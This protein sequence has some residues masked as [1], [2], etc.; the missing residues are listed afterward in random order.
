MLEHEVL[1]AMATGETLAAAMDR[2][3]RRV[4]GLAPAAICS[5]LEVD[6]DG[7]LHPLAAPSLPETYSAALDGI[8]IGPKV[9]SC[10][11]A[12][13]LRREVDVTDIATDPLWDDYR[14]LVEPLGLRGC[15]SS[16]ILAADGK[17]LGTFAFYYREKDGARNIERHIVDACVPLCAIVMEH[18][19]ARAERERL[20]YHDGLTGLANRAAFFRRAQHMIAEAGGDGSLTMLYLDL[21]GFKDV[22][23]SLGHFAG[24]Q[25]LAAVGQRLLAFA[26]N[27][28]EVARIGGDEFA[29]LV[30]GSDRGRAERLAHKL[31][32]LFDRPIEVD[33]QTVTMRAS[34]GIAFREAGDRDLIELLKRADLA[35]YRAKADGGGRPAFFHSELAGVVL[36]RRELENDLNK[37]IR[38]REFFL[39]Y[40]PIVDLATGAV[41]GCEG[42]VRW[43]HP[44]AGL[45]PPSDFIGTAEELGLIIPIGAWVL[46]EGCRAAT[47]WPEGIY[48]AINLSAVQLREPGFD[49]TVATILSRTGLP[50]SR[51]QLEITESVLLA[52]SPVTRAT[53]SQLRAIGVG[54]ALDDFGTGYSSL[55]SIRAFRPDTIKIDQ[56][57]IGELGV[58]E[59]ATTIVRAVIALAGNLGMTTTAEG[60]E[61]AEQARL[62]VEEGC[63]EG[64]G[65]HFARPMAEEQLALLLATRRLPGVAAP[66]AAAG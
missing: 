29:L 14:H 37:A 23:D 58:D 27:E 55:R 19:R 9:G 50:A 48:V 57:F 20:A 46:E 8:R 61:T 44:T 65:Y 22:N 51:L 18:E 7:I 28:G 56:S 32:A 12:A 53:L 49:A 17:A 21:D 63:R 5:I 34:I 64:Q 40:Q 16:P 41:T 54:I 24:D 62:L 36:R 59:Q 13:F 45:R 6:K 11:T 26:A 2:L 3:C 66:R 1:K 42:L 15:W 10:G 43:L 4:E 35:L 39:V 25:L 38:A 47:R 33:G 52:E 30:E 31:L 60:I